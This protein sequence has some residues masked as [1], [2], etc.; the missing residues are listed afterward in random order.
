MTQ[1]TQSLRYQ[2]LCVIQRGMSFSTPEIALL[3]WM[4]TNFTKKPRYSRTR[5]LKSLFIMKTCQTPNGRLRHLVLLL[6]F[7]YK[8]TTC[9]RF[10]RLPSLFHVNI[11]AST[12]GWCRPF[13]T[14]F[15]YFFSIHVAKVQRNPQPSRLG[16]FKNDLFKHI[17]ELAYLSDDQ[18]QYHVQLW[19]DLA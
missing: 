8:Q 4:Y 11:D 5:A 17:A 7:R 10:S 13:C 15:P 16:T 19:Q 3:S 2:N 1:T 14:F 9:C 18:H 6:C 12:M